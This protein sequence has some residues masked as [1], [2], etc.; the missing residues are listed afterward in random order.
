MKGATREK[1]KKNSYHHGHLREALLESALVLLKEA[2]LESLTLREVARRA[3]VSPGAPY[4][5]FKDKAQLVQALAQRSL[6]TLDQLSFE[7]VQDKKMP[8]EKL[9][10]LGFAYI[11][12]AVRHPAEF[13]LM[14]RPEMSSPLEFPD[15]KTA[16][17]FRVLLSVIAGSSETE[18]QQ[19]T[20][21]I[22]A[23]S[24][25]HG[26][27]V[28]L[29]DGPLHGLTSHQGQLEKLIEAVTARIDL[30]NKA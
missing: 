9:H 30:A 12:Y 17:V 7:A 3:G 2:G 22:S 20:T 8:S 25:V 14:F 21:A 5:H 23:W 24:L 16:P 29:I 6:E 18:Q 28:L 4:H 10:A 1:V 13:R 19:L 15:P 26:L 11:L 27:A